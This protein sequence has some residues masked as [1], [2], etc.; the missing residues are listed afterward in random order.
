[1]NQ[2]NL[3]GER[4]LLTVIVSFQIERE[5]VDSALPGHLEAGQSEPFCQIRLSI[6]KCKIKFLD[7]DFIYI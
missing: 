2:P 6:A 5:C 4:K 3:T 1:M 7:A